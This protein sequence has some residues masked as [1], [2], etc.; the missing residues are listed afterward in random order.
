L[1]GLSYWGNG[2]AESVQTPAA[3]RTVENA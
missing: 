2:T 3:S 1:S